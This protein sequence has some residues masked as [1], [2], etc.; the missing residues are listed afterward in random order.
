MKGSFLLA[1][2]RTDRF[3]RPPENQFTTAGGA[4]HIGWTG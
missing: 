3:K 1:Q 4:N 2:K